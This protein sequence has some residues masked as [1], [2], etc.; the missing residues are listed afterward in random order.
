M[1][2]E[3]KFFRNKNHF[4]IYKIKKLFFLYIKNMFNILF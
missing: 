4:L 3:E 2:K 1:I